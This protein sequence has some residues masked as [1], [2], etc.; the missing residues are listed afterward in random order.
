MRFTMGLI[1]RQK[2]STSS[3]AMVPLIADIRKLELKI[4]KALSDTPS[5]I[6]TLLQLSQKLDILKASRSRQSPFSSH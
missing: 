3:S 6:Q 1:S 4:A 5:N 2:L